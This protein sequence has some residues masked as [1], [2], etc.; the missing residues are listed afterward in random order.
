MASL[1]GLTLGDALGD[2]FFGED[3]EARR[4]V[5]ARELRPGVW[6]WTD[7]TAQAV[8]L[9]HNWSDY[10]V[11]DAE[12][13]SLGL[14]AECKLD[15][16]RGY[17]RGAREVLGAISRG[18]S[19]QVASAAVFDGEGSLGNGAAMRVAPLGAAL[20]DQEAEVVV[21][22][23]EAASRVTHW[24]AEGVAGGVAVALAAW[25]SAR[26]GTPADM[27]RVVLERVTEGDLLHRL[28]WASEIGS[29]ERAVTRLGTGWNA[30]ALDTVP[31]ALWCAGHWWDSFEDA[32]WGTVA[33]LGDRDTTCAIVG[34]VLGGRLAVPEA[35][36]DRLEPWV[37]QPP[38]A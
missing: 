30:T 2:T 7:D 5:A 32:F 28:R 21:A 34:G 18:E 1:L 36:K 25:V 15:P 20:A 6:R 31:W 16:E 35:W 3:G 17:G 12:E 29:A 9:L 8:V 10:G 19:W 37:W 11:V 26:G 13:L 4:R 22:Q 24:H 33:G 38:L 23:A 27:W 14:A